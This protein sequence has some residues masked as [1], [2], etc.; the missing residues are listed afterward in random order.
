MISFDMNAVKSDDSR[1]KSIAVDITVFEKLWERNETYRGCKLQDGFSIAEKSYAASFKSYQHLAVRFACKIAASHLGEKSWDQFE[2]LR[3]E[4]G[5]PYIKHAK[6]EVL[7]SLTHDG[8][9]AIAY[10]IFK[11]I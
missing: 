8:S 4:S 7:I 9:W 1:Q 10:V 6:Q 11:P 5:S 3:T 2:I